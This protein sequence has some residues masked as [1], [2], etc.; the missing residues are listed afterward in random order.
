MA[1]PRNPYRAWAWAACLSAYAALAA[2]GYGFAT[3]NTPL[4]VVAYAVVFSAGLV[5]SLLDWH[6]SKSLARQGKPQAVVKKP[7]AG[8]NLEPETLAPGLVWIE[9][10]RQRLH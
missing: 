7:V 6:H 1:S 3:G 2:I 9:P 10:E 8:R 5:P 4:L